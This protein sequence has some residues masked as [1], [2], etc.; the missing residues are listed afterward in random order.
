MHRR[1][2]V[3]LLVTLALVACA[4][5]Q[6]FKPLVFAP[7]T[8]LQDPLPGKAV[9]YLLR[10]PTE[11]TTV[12][13]FFNVKRMAV[14]PPSTFT[15]VMVDPGTYEV[16]STEGIWSSSK[17]PASRLTVS[18]GERRFLYTSVPRRASPNMFFIPLGPPESCR[19]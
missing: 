13:V 4:T 15:A 17:T 9:V 8:R 7:D 18:A 14:L 19:S 10:V 12:T 6:P 16:A 11:G 1:S 2:S 3:T 5:P